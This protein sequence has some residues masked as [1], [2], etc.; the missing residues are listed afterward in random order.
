MNP[1]SS[2]GLM[3]MLR[4]LGLFNFGDNND[5]VAKYSSARVKQEINLVLDFHWRNLLLSMFSEKYAASQDFLTRHPNIL[6][7]AINA[8]SVWPRRPNAVLHFDDNIAETFYNEFTEL[9]DKLLTRMNEPGF[10]PDS[11]SVPSDPESD[12]SS[13]FIATPRIDRIL[14]NI[15]EQ[16]NLQ[17]NH[18]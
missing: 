2:C 10:H 14:S 13:D 4:M 5:P 12:S 11:L 6:T 7:K 1:A 3:R 17:R 9:S 18:L 8:E 16:Q 15:V